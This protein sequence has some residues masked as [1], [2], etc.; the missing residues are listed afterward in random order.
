M[1][2]ITVNGS[3]KAVP[4]DWSIAQLLGD[5]QMR[6]QWVAVEVNEQLVPRTEHHARQLA[7]GDRLEI[8]TLVGGG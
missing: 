6:P 4:A 2:E 3:P 1:L 8:V 7:A 5:M